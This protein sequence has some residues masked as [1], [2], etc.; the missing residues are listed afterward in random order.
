MKS[1][2]LAAA[3]VVLPALLGAQNCQ[4]PAPP[5][6]CTTANLTTPATIT[7]PRTVLLTM[8]TTT[9]AATTTITDFD[10]SR[11]DIAGPTA[12][13]NGNRA[14]TLLMTATA[15]TLTNTGVGSRPN[16]PTSDITWSTAAAGTFVP[17]TTSTVQIATGTATN[18]TVTSL[19]YRAALDW[20]LD[21]PG[22][23]SVGVTF[24]L[25]T[26]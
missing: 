13:V 21:K 25:T 16:K 6:S 12:T 8:S 1:M 19:F 9:T 23:Y 15:S 24:T 18:S 11:I 7:I 2:L 22:V 14:W 3:L 4:V 20:T 26:P 10:N 17:L 5:G